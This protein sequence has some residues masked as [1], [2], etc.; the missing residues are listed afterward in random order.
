ML[1]I[2]N[3]TV[4]T[5]AGPP[6][7]GA[8]IVI[9]EGKIAVV[10]QVEIPTDSEV[11]D[12]LGKI[13]MPGLIEAH[14]HLGIAEEIYRYEGDDINE[15]TDPLTPH[16]R[17]IDA[18]NPADI[19]F[20]DARQGGVTTVFTGP[21]SA[22]VVGGEGVILKTAG[23]VVDRMILKAPAGLKIAFGENPKFAYQH[24]KKM[25]STRMGTAA[26]LRQL[27]NEARNYL[28]RQQSNRNNHDKFPDCDLRLEAVTRVLRREIPLRAHAHRADDMMTAIR[29]AAEYE[30]D[31]VLEHATEGHLIA[32]E[33]AARGVPA[34]VGPS[35]SN[36]SKVELKE[37]TFSTPA[38]LAAQG[39]KVAIMTDHPVVPIEY[40]SL[41]AALAHKEG[42]TEMQAL[43]AITIDAARILGVADRIGSIE[44]GKDADLIILNGPLFNLMTRVETV[45]ING[46]VV[47]QS[48][49]R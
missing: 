30:M 43:R 21:G 24:Q 14:C 5:M 17:A 10:G 11:I 36:R 29:I 8:T 39:V 7:P 19:G 26:L 38:V 12:A 37:K 3:A 42:L 27:L 47:Y 20:Q 45:F 23:T 48:P 1:F 2:K 18:I 13:V 35:L 4:Y 25:P 34:V 22:N 16:L 31:L 49:H 6:L 32:G 40:L 9:N 28:Q 33:L 15:T 41:C 44:P 46:Q